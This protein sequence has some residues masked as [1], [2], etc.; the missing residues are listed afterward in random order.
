LRGSISALRKTERKCE[1]L[2]RGKR[3]R[4]IVVRPH[5]KADDAVCFITAR[6]Q[7]EDRNVVGLICAQVAAEREAV[8]P[9]QHQV[10]HD[11]IDPVVCENLAHLPAVGYRSDPIA[12]AGK[13]SVQQLAQTQ[14]IVDDKNVGR[15]SHTRQSTQPARPAISHFVT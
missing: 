6:R 7:H 10:K 2:T 14:I 9:R 12:V 3:L 13:V 1:Q 11:Q 15:I 4:K 5:L 8:V